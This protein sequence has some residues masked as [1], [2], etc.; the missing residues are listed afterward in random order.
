MIGMICTV[1]LPA[2]NARSAPDV[3]R[4]ERS[5]RL[6][7]MFRHWESEDVTGEPDWDPTSLVRFGLPQQ[8][9]D[10]PD[11]PTFERE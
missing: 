3:L 10:R 2:K 11:D 9:L 5:V 1:A 8:E 6:E 7:A 4:E